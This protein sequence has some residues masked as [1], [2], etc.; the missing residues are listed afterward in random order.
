MKHQFNFS[1][2]PIIAGVILL[3]CMTQSVAQTASNRQPEGRLI[4][5]VKAKSGKIIYLMEQVTDGVNA[6]A[7]YTKSGDKY[8]KE[9]VFKVKGKYCS[10]IKSVD[11]ENWTTSAPGGDYFVLNKNDNTLY[12]PLLNIETSYY[13]GADHDLVTSADRYLLYQFDGE[14]FVYKRNDGGFW[15]NKDLRSFNDLVYVGKT[16]DY[17]VRI[18]DTKDGFRYA[19][20]KVK[21]GMTAKPDLVLTDKVR[22]CYGVQLDLGFAFESKGYTYEVWTKDYPEGPQLIVKQG[23]KI[24]LKQSLQKVAF[25]P[26]Y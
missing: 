6:V 4:G 13:G 23:D 1:L 15:L 21:N 25:N 26:K 17:L 10:V 19:A 3:V 9:N 14:H 12:L 24:L 22:L 8:V 20:W 16:K 18:D 7:S 2:R 5:T 11:C